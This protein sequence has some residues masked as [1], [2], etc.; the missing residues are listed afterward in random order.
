MSREGRQERTKHSASRRVQHHTG[1]VPGA[2]H[3]PRQVDA[4]SQPLRPRPAVI[5][6]GSPEWIRG[7]ARDRRW[8]SGH[9]KRLYDI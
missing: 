2:T 8:L 6:H 7:L 1:A 4:P 3:A 5:R 9:R